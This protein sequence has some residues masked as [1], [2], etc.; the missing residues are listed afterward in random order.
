MDI[1]EYASLGDELIT[2]KEKR[3]AILE[4]LEARVGLVWSASISRPRRKYSW[5][6][7]RLSLTALLWS[8]SR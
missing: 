5:T 2:L 4:T 8:I 7:S 3:E 1:L 6:M